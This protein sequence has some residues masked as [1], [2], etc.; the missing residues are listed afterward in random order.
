[1]RYPT[2]E[3]RQAAWDRFQS[4]VQGV[5]RVFPDGLF[6]FLENFA[7]RDAGNHNGTANGVGWPYLPFGGLSASAF[8]RLQPIM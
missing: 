6:Q 8:T 4:L 5:K 7:S 1:V 2:R 3:A